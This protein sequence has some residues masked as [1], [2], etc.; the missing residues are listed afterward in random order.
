MKKFSI[1]AWAISIGIWAALLASCAHLPP[2]TI[3]FHDQEGLWRMNPDGHAIQQIT[4]FGWSG[5]YSPDNS[6]I[7][8]GEFYDQGIWVA[9]ANGANPL[10]LTTFGSA[11]SWSPDGSRL[12]FHTGGQV[13][14]NRYLWVM[15]ADGSNAHQL[16]TVNGSF[17]DWSPL[18]DKILFHGEV[19]SGI[20]QISP[21]GSGER[22][23]YR[24]GG[25]PAWSPDGQKIAYV[26]L[27]DWSIWV[28]NHDGTDQRKLTDHSGLLPAWS[29]AGDQIAYERSGEETAGVWIIQ[30]DGSGD[31]RINEK[32]NQP[33]WSN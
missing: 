11:P 8:F 23:L 32:G 12:A 22:L 24:N 14:V 1:S 18:G 13:G 6:K 19:N 3:I 30:I 26:D 33:D 21:D 4:D 7:A 29:A 25:Y 2:T 31:H 9:D 10:R 17:A 5:A 20:W 16:S 15:N 28:M 27:S